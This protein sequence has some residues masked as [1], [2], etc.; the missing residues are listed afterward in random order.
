MITI[1]EIREKYPQYNDLSDEQLVNGLHSKFYNDITK[2][3]YYKKIGFNPNETNKSN[4]LNKPESELSKIPGYAM[5]AAFDFPSTIISLLSQ[6][7]ET[8]KNIATHPINSFRDVLGGVARGSQ[9]VAASGL[10]AGEYLTRKI[11][12]SLPGA[13]KV[14]YWNAREFMGLEGP[15]KIDLGKMIESKNPDPLISGIGQYG[16]GSASSGSKLLPM[17]LANFLTGGIQSPNRENRIENAVRSG[18][19]AAIPGSAVK[20]IASLSP[21]N[22]IT[23]LVGSPLSKEELLRNL[24]VTK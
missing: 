5:N 13:G 2:E 23:K 12:E 15:D 17:I 22:L 1:K 10:E 9:N 18:V 6:I 19:S 3:D 7:P 8:A 14:P 16:L 20:G 4:Q 24:E 21:S 11:A